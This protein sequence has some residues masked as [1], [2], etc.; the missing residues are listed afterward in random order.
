MVRF[1][2]HILV[3]AITAAAAAAPSTAA[4]MIDRSGAGQ[5]GE[6]TS[7]TFTAPGSAQSASN[8]FD[9][10]DAGIGAAASAVLIG[11]G[12]VYSR[13]RPARRVAAS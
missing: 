3:V 11:G 7:V 6:P 1:T 8:A 13:R 9:W 5:P 12:M 2:K 4:A 10:G